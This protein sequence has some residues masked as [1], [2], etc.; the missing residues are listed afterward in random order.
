MQAVLFI[1]KEIF[2]AERTEIVVFWLDH[3][4]EGSN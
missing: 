4:D 3:E 2:T 1:Q